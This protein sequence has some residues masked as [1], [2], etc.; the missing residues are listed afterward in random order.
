M[1]TTKARATTQLAAN[2]PEDHPFV[3]AMREATLT[4]AQ[5][6]AAALEIRHVVAAFPRFLA[7]LIAQIPAHPERMVLVE[8]LFHEH[9]AMNA[10]RVHEVTYRG[11]LTQ[12]G[13]TAAEIDAHR[14]GLAATVYVRALLDL[15]GRGPIT[16]ALGA[17]GV[18]EEIVARVSVAVR[19]YGQHTQAGAESHFSVHEVLDVRHAD[20]LYE[21]CDTYLASGDAESVAES[22]ARGLALGHYYH[23]RLYTDVASIISLV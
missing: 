2:R 14:P 5:A 7:A 21:L 19:Q 1:I 12:L 18:I 20:E 15:S 9:G 23:L 17:L 6:K 22:V 4:P 16:E 10:S 8:N 11:F 13:L 3:R